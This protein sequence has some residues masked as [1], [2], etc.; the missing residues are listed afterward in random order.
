M[1]PQLV[2]QTGAASLAVKPK[3]V[4][5]NGNYAITRAVSEIL[6]ETVDRNI[7]DDTLSCNE[8]GYDTNILSKG[9]SSTQ[10]VILGIV[11]LRERS[12]E[13]EILNIQRSLNTQT[14][15]SAT[16]ILSEATGSLGL[17]E[18]NI[19][20]TIQSG[21]FRKAVNDITAVYRA[22]SNYLTLLADVFAYNPGTMQRFSTTFPGITNTNNQTSNVVLAP[23]VCT[24]FS[25]YQNVESW[26]KESVKVVTPESRLNIANVMQLCKNGATF[27]K[28]NQ[29]DEIVASGDNTYAIDGAE[30]LLYQNAI[31][32]LESIYSREII[33]NSTNFSSQTDTIFNIV[34][35][36]M[37]LQFMYRG[38]ESIGT[39]LDKILGNLSNLDKSQYLLTNQD[40]GSF[41]PIV[42]KSLSGRR[43]LSLDSVLTSQDQLSDFITSDQ[44][45]L[46]DPIKNDVNLL[47]IRAGELKD[48]TNVLI[49]NINDLLAPISIGSDNKLSNMFFKAMT[50]FIDGSILI[51]SGP[52]LY[53]NGEKS[54]HR[55]E[56]WNDE[57][58]RQLNNAMRLC[59]FFKAANNTKLMNI[60]FKIMMLRDRIRHTSDYLS[61]NTRNFVKECEKQLRFYV[62]ELTTVYFG[63]KASDDLITIDDVE[64]QLDAV[65]KTAFFLDGIQVGRG[66]MPASADFFSTALLDTVVRLL[67]T[68]TQTLW[69]HIFDSCNIGEQP[70]PGAEMINND[71]FTVQT[72]NT[73]QLIT[74]NRDHRAFAIFAKMLSF[75]QSNI[76]GS[77]FLSTAYSNEYSTTSGGGGDEVR[78]NVKWDYAYFITL[79]TVCKFYMNQTNNLGLDNEPRFVAWRYDFEI[80][81]ESQKFLDQAAASVY[82]VQLARSLGINESEIRVRQNKFELP[83]NFDVVRSSFGDLNTF[84]I[85]N[86]RT[87]LDSVQKFYDCFSFVSSYLTSVRRFEQIAADSAFRYVP[88]YGQDLVSLYTLNSVTELNKLAR[89][90]LSTSSEMMSFSPYYFRPTQYLA[91]MLTYANNVLPVTQDS[92]VLLCGIPYGM[93]ERLGGFNTSV[94]KDVKITLQFKQV[95]IDSPVVYEIIKTYPAASF[96]DPAVQIFSEIDISTDDSIISKSILYYLNV[97]TGISTDTFTQDDIKKNEV[98]STAILEYLRLLYGIDLDLLSFNQD[99][100]VNLNELF[101]NSADLRQKV[102]N[103]VASLRLSDLIAS[104]YNTSVLNSINFQQEDTIKRALSGFTFDKIVAI[105]IDADKLK[106]ASGS[107]LCDVIISVELETKEQIGNVPIFETSIPRTISSKT[108]QIVQA[109][110]SRRF[111]GR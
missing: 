87:T 35:K 54:T 92:F 4:V 32:M 49:E 36:E 71:P 88:T 21:S 45:Y 56:G 3:D 94:E 9:I 13:I 95:Q 52:N 65:L 102:T 1:K 62:D 29:I 106:S 58:D 38:G 40:L 22:K 5:Q 79:S 47:N 75:F 2:F 108:N 44:Y 30:N 50:G 27:L 90:A 74:T 57:L 69:D 39:R 81:I 73:N 37:M 53:V 7:T 6:K 103:Y 16:T 63:K 84:F 20:N 55:G 19:V 107:F 33:N 78:W 70:S 96:I 77:K 34:D 46:I 76:T 24:T 26:A 31:Q 97:N 86:L 28:E 83:I 98:E 68:D 23:V 25:I 18:K 110:Q 43:I 48:V 61:G 11:P 104:R 12:Q 99:T 14:L 64:S 91:G 109:Q 111:T 59:I 105:P 60:V 51:E 80:S 72:G 66:T 17:L 67:D 42:T 100:E 15:R 10:P 41:N 82:A 101:P 89:K 8:S 85:N 93:I